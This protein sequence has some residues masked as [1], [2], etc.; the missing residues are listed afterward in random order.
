MYKIFSKENQSTEQ[1]KDIMNVRDNVKPTYGV[2]LKEGND[3]N[4]EGPD[5][6]TKLRNNSSNSNTKM[7]KKEYK[8][9]F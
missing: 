3:F 7:S 2:S 1:S 6:A 8:E 5:Y 4:L 9:K